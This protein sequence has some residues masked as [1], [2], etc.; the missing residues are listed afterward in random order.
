MAESRIVTTPA[1]GVRLGAPLAGWTSS[2]A[3]E[4]MPDTVMARAFLTAVLV[5]AARQAT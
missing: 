3:G 1:P 2:S 5:W 4:S